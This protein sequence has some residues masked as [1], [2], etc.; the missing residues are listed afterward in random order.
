MDEDGNT[1]RQILVSDF[2]MVNPPAIDIP[3]MICQPE[4]NYYYWLTSNLASGVGAVVEFGTWLGASTAFLSAGLDG[5]AMHCYDHFE[6]FGYDNWKSD[7]KLGDGADFTDLFMSNVERY[8]ANVVVHKTKMESAVWDGG[9]VELLILDAPKQAFQLAK[10]LIVFAPSFIP[11]Q[12]RLVLQDYQHF[13]SYELAVVMDAIRSSVVLDHV[14]VALDN[15]QPNTV[16]FLVLKPLDIGALTEVVGAFK[17]WPAGRILETWRRI[18]APLPDQARARMAPGLAL[19]LS[20][21]GHGEEAVAQLA[22]TPM[23]RIMLKRWR[24]LCGDVPYFDFPDRYRSLVAF[25]D[26]TRLNPDWNEAAQ[27]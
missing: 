25:M 17:T 4:K 7:I 18:T 1:G 27:A 9:P 8:G 6:W 2:S 11:G 21:A 13:P 23:D 16:S 26:E 24:R 22:R 20:D 19:F 5:R 10:L 14:V 3:A 12:T 15:K